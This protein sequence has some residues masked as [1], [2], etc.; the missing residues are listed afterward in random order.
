MNSFVDLAVLGKPEALKKF[1]T[2]PRVAPA[3]GCAP[4]PRNG[5]PNQR[6]V[7]GTAGVCV[8]RWRRF[9][10]DLPFI[11]RSRTDFNPWA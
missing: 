8:I 6:N 10:D 2:C 3:N 4:R 9:S 11:P 7:F 1:L 5:V